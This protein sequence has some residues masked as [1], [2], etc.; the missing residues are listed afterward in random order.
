M[1]NAD[2]TRNVAK[3]LNDA[4]QRAHL[5]HVITNF[6]R[7]RRGLFN[8]DEELAAL[9]EAANAVKRRVVGRLAEVLERLEAS[10]AANGIQ[11]HW[12]E[13]GEEASN[14]VLD[15]TRSVGGK[16]LVKSKSMVT[17]EIH[18]NKTLEA[19]GCEI[20]E[21]D[22]GEF[23]IQLIGQT[24]FH[25][26]APALHV[27]KEQVGAIFAEKIGIDYTEDP[28]RLQA[29]ARRFLRERFR[30]ADVGVTGVNFAVA[31]TGTICVVENEGN[32]RMCASVPRVHVAVTGLEKIVD[33]LADLPLMLRMLV[34]SAT[35]QRIST[36]F[37]MV[38]GPRRPGDQD[39]PE[40][41]HL[42]LLDNGRSR[43][44]GDEELRQSLQCLRCGACLNHCPVFKRIGGHAY[45]ATYPGP[46]GTMVMPQLKGLDEYGYMALAS[47][48]CGACGEVCPVMVPIP[49]IIRRLRVEAHDAHGAVLDHGHDAARM[50]SLAW[51]LWA[52]VMTS[53]GL[54]AMA[55]KTMAALGGALPAVGPLGAW[56]SVRVRP[57]FS[58]KG[59][60]DLLREEDAKE[61]G[62][63]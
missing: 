16:T 25:I 60:A 46:V 57:K 3:A 14:I 34:G 13:T 33:R 21:T 23:I 45:A 9:R 8:D 31:E 51:S 50:E 55:R 6:M 62:S 7:G 43:M 37:N 5:E 32:A 53:P 10:C 18:L 28:D 38:G 56:T 40:Q 12:A 19:N 42:V 2:F 63:K 30:R 26:I 29:E 15:I 24:P 47:S 22:L 1:H 20:R 4:P 41:V 17:E 39:G 48:L 35:G 54:N 61:K 58:S 11:V 27:T 36:Y 52:K 49:S 44:A 59:L